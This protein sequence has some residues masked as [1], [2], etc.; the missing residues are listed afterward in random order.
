MRVIFMVST[1]YTEVLLV[2]SDYS[3]WAE[4]SSLFNEK[5]TYFIILEEP[6]YVAE[7]LV[8][9]EV[10]RVTNIIAHINPKYVILGN[11]SSKIEAK[12]IDRFPSK[13]TLINIKGREEIEEK[14]IRS[15]NLE[16]RATYYCNPR[17]LALWLLYAKSNN[18]YLIP[19]K[20]EPIKFLNPYLNGSS[21]RLVW[22]ENNNDIEDIIASNYS[23]AWDDS[24]LS[25][26][27][28]TRQQVDNFNDR[29]RTIWNSKMIDKDKIDAFDKIRDQINTWICKD[30]I[31]NDYHHALFVTDDIPYSF[32]FRN[33]IPIS[34]MH[35]NFLWLSLANSYIHAREIYPLIGNAILFST[36]NFSIW[37]EM[38]VVERQLRKKK[39]QL[40]LLYWKNA[41]ISK[42]GEYANVLPYSILHICSHGWNLEG[43]TIVEKFKDNLWIEHTIEYDEVKVIEKPE[44]LKSADPN[45]MIDIFVFQSF[46]K[47]DWV[48]WENNLKKEGFMDWI[49]NDKKN[50]WNDRIILS[51]RPI[52]YIRYSESVICYDWPNLC[53]FHS[54]ASDGRPLVFN[55]S[56]SSFHT[57]SY[58]FSYAGARWYIWTLW[59]IDEDVAKE[60]AED[61]Y[62]N[63]ENLPVYWAIRKAQKG[64]SKKAQ[65]N[66]FVYFWTDLDSIFEIPPSE[67]NNY[68]HEL[69]RS[70]GRWLQYINDCKENKKPERLIEE[71][72]DRL[73]LLDMS[74][75]SESLTRMIKNHNKYFN[76][77]L[78]LKLCNKQLN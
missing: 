39:Y 38:D 73:K 51:K 7:E 77:N 40:Q 48:I 69:V 47:Y 34:H 2:T 18:Y 53:S 25:I 21:K 58:K 28:F 54:L 27:A 57:L 3:L 50:I 55:N 24:L 32:V 42:F 49:E 8:D 29:I 44:L 9:N 20:N 62:Q 13:D 52:N 16:I 43:N 12:I 45:D 19:D 67:E 10:T 22:F 71:T 33:I 56:C 14:L 60:V 70:I 23:F 65:Q 46:V 26:P 17:E 37:D 68:F 66:I 61:F 15:L 75:K 72:Q 59:N 31:I 36:K 5:D 11:L 30:I 41:T 76:N 64:I 4:I 35:R 78:Y 74:L 1:I 6:R 63:I